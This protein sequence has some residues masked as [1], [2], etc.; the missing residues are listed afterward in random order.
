VGMHSLRSTFVNRAHN[1]RVRDYELLTGH[2]GEQSAVV[3]GYRGE[4][5]LRQKRDI[6]ESITFDVEPLR[7]ASP[8]TR[9]K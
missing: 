5:D 6:L 2:A 4:L 1:L 3:R 8:P 7:P 9:H